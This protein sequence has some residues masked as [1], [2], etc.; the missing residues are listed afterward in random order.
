MMNVDVIGRAYDIA[1]NYLRKTGAIP[2]S[3]VTYDPLLE[4]I[5]KMFQRGEGNPLRLANKAIS[6]FEAAAIAA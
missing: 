2:D 1:A 5:V 3:A 4:M 6:H